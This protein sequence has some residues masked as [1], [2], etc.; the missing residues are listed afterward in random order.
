[1]NYEVHSFVGFGIDDPID[2]RPAIVLMMLMLLR[3]GCVE[4]C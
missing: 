1:M 3:K 2:E 4:L